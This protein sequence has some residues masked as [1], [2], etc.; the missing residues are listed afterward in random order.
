MVAGVPKLKP[1]SVGVGVALVAVLKPKL[2][3]A[4]VWVGTAGA[5]VNPNP[6]EAAGWAVEQALSA[7]PPAA[8]CAGTVPK[9]KAAGAAVW[10]VDPEVSE[11]HEVVLVVVAAAAVLAAGTLPKEKPE[12]GGAAGLPN[13][14][15]ALFIPSEKPPAVEVAAGCTGRQNPVAGAVPAAGV[16]NENK[17]ALG[18]E[19]VA[20]AAAGACCGV[21]KPKPPWE[22]PALLPKENPPGVPAA[23]LGV[24]N[25]KP[26]PPAGLPKLKLILNPG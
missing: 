11:K 17:L 4:V 18:A 24:A 14:K 19:V 23:V 10:A 9:L 20:A 8:G 7:K 13:P 1:V 15:L 16:V 2:P 21:P 6:V 26:L 22:P 5:A 3:A 12:T 25:E